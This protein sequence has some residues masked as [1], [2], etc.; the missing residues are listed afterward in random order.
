MSSRIYTYHKPRRNRQ[1]QRATYAAFRRLCELWYTGI[2]GKW[3][4]FL[5]HEEDQCTKSFWHTYLPRAYVAATRRLV[6][7]DYSLS[8]AKILRIYAQFM[9]QL[10]ARECRP[11]PW[12]IH[13]KGCLEII[14]PIDISYICNAPPISLRNRS[15]NYLA[16]RKL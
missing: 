14:D 15:V 16:L 7:G 13:A 11:L 4:Y 12:D 8:S 5:D 10:I 6:S 1:K 2:C 9:R 3:L